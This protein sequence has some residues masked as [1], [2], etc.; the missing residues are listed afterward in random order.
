V[1]LVRRYIGKGIESDWEGEVA[2]MEINEVI[3]STRWNAIEKF[4]GEIAVR[5]NQADAVTGGDVLHDEIPQQ[6][7]FSG[8][9]L[10]DDIEVMALVGRRNAKGDF[11]APC[12]LV[13]DVSKML[14]HGAEASRHS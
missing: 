13:A 11:V 8:A 12:V 6:R 2:R 4:F 1:P 3:R 5:I 14:I 10:A 7:R 9:R